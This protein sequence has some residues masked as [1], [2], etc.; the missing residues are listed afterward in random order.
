M[1]Y[2]YSFVQ[3][4]LFW[5]ILGAMALGLL[6]VRLTGGYNF[7]PAFCLLAALVMI[8]PSLVPLDFDRI[9]EIGSHKR[10]ILLSIIINF[11]VSPSI[12]VVLGWFFLAQEPALWLGLILLSILPGGGMVT[13][14]AYRSKAD[15]PFTVGIVFANLLA[16][17][18]LAPFYLTLAINKLSVLQQASSQS[19][20]LDAATKGAA[21]C[22]FGGAGAISPLKIAAPIGVIIIMPLILAYATQ[23]YLGRKHNKERLTAIK[24]Q[25]AA[26]SNLGMLLVL[27]V[28]MGIDQ[29]VIIFERP[30]ILVKAIVP[31]TLFYISSLSI[32]LLLYR[33]RGGAEGKALA[34]GTFL[35]YITLALGLAISLI[36]QSPEYGL[37]VI[38]VIVAYLVQI[39]SS[40]WLAKKFNKL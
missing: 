12:A 29:N 13:T 35:R 34:W 24:Q 7:T 40:F 10:L 11:I 37:T 8:Y 38:M 1:S 2:I 32:S 9:K 27:F 33:R 20:L 39:P 30:D 26:V 15:M 6:L 25:F 36:Y 17:V 4:Y 22:L 14:W 21:T 23:K 18:A 3:R 19:C 5:L 16:A 31:L 28:L